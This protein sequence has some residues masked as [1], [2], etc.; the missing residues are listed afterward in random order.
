MIS[1]VSK[2]LKILVVG[3]EVGVRDGVGDPWLLD[4]RGGEAGQLTDVKLEALE[5]FGSGKRRT[6]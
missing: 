2:R 3:F 6:V 4:R 1:N 5:A